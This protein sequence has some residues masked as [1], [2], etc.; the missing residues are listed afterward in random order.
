MK[1]KDK[2]RVMHYVFICSGY[3]TLYDRKALLHLQVLSHIS[4]IQRLS[5]ATSV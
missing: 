2:Q 1:Q 3:L 4:P 5:L